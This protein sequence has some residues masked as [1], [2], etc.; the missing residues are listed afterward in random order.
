MSMACAEGE[1]G[2]QIRVF[3]D[4][5]SLTCSWLFAFVNLCLKLSEGLLD[6]AEGGYFKRGWC[7]VG[8]GKGWREG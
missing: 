8:G 3:K 5:K 7:E 1:Q 6:V 4:L 2:G